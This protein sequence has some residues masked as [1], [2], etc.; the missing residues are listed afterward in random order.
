MQSAVLLMPF[1][2]VSIQG[3]KK[4]TLSSP[5]P[6]FSLLLLE[7]MLYLLSSDTLFRIR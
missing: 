7:Q 2:L 6:I 5:L 1:V 4:G 3:Q